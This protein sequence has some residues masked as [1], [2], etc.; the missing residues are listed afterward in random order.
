[1]LRSILNLLI[2]H[3]LIVSVN[4]HLKLNYYNECIS[5]I[6]LEMQPNW[7]NLKTQNK[8][9]YSRIAYLSTDRL[10]V[11]HETICSLKKKGLGCSFCSIPLSKTTFNMDDIKE[12]INNLLDKP[13]FRHILIGGG[14]GNPD[15]EYKQ[16][17]EISKSIRAVNSNIPIYLM[18]LPPLKADILMQYKSAG[19]TEIA[20]NIEIW[21]RSLAKELMPGKGLIPLE[22][23]LRALKEGTKIWGTT[24]NVRTA[25]IVGLDNMD[26]LLEGV[27]YL[28]KQGIQPMISIFRPMVNTKLEALVPP[29]NKVLLS[30]YEKAQDICKQHNLKLGPT[31]D[32]CKNNMLAI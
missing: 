4:K 22:L 2:Y 8:V 24:G 10:R 7:S 14:S 13:K 21:N 20:F 3:H 17:I 18:S 32:A 1:M 29:S 12:V 28:S 6:Y 27:E 30:F 16:I 9:P 25:L 15:T 31:C 26:T 11:K 19:I 5:E 23:Y